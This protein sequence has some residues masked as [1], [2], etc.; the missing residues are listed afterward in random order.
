MWIALYVFL[1]TILAVD[2]VYTIV[3]W[4]CRNR[5]HHWKKYFGMLILLGLEAAGIALLIGLIVSA[6]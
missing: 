3:F 4:L 2:F 5:P 6:A 1:I